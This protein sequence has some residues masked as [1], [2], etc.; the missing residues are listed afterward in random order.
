[1][2]SRQTRHDVTISALVRCG[3]AVSSAC[4]LNAS[5]RGLLVFAATPPLVGSYIELDAERHIIVARVVWTDGHHFGVQT[6]DRVPSNLVPDIDRSIAEASLRRARDTS[7]IFESNRSFGKSLQ[8]VCILI[9]GMA[10][11]AV[12]YECV[13]ASLARPVALV[14]TALAG[15]AGS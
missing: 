10:M 4:I 8:F 5:L 15:P 3:L 11:G 9:F 14:R 12:A 13:Q 1:M 2:K 6:Q 7:T